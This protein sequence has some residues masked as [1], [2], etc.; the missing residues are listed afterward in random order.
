MLNYFIFR[1]IYLFLIYL[2][3]AICV[4]FFFFTCPY[5]V[6]KSNLPKKTWIL[7]RYHRVVKNEDDTRHRDP[8][9]TVCH[10]LQKFT[11]V[12]VFQKFVLWYAFRNI[13]NLIYCYL[14]SCLCLNIVLYFKPT[15]DNCKIFSLEIDNYII[16]K[17][18]I[19]DANLTC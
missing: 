18:S 15:R 11:W 14:F 6:Q 13:Y 3:N 17:C 4:I 2:N 10:Q 1:N 12:P 19:T 9:V 5:I 8:W 16:Y 7:H